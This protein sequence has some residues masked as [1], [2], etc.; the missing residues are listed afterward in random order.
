LG[1]VLRGGAG[2]A[3]IEVRSAGS[4]AG[5]AVRVKSRSAESSQ[6]SRGRCGETVGARKAIRSHYI[7]VT[8]HRCV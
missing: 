4:V 1:C 2:S 6:G 3:G 8:V 7:F 5:S